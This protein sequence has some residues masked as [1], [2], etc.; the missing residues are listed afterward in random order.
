MLCPD[1]LDT[2]LLEAP[3]MILARQHSW[4]SVQSQSNEI[5]T[6]RKSDARTRARTESFHKIAK[7][8]SVI[9]HEVLL[10]CDASSHRFNLS[11]PDMCPDA[12]TTIS[13]PV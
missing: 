8:L 10:E 4:I 12:S 13:R 3:A 11:Q 5:L 2:A 7:A 9:S 6:A 1:V